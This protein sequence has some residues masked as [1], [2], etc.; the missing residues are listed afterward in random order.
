M[1][2]S[3]YLR[4]AEKHLKSC[5]AFLS[6]YQPNKNNDFE[7]FMELF[8]ITGYVLEG[9]TVYS[10]YKIYG[11]PSNVAI[12]DL[13]YYDPR[14]IRRTNLDFFHYRTIVNSDGSRSN[15]IHRG[16]KVRS[17]GFQQ[18]TMQLL[19]NQGPFVNDNLT[20][21]YG[22]GP[23]DSNVRLLINLWSPEVR[24]Y[25]RSHIGVSVLPT[26]NKEL[27]TKLIDTCSL[28]FSQTISRVGI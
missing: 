9:L 24:Y 3:E 5:K 13:N 16:L 20:P 10:A 22:N 8:Y 17:H 15:R 2:Y 28:I 23:L 11:W 27:I 26:L 14:F 4:C 7:V 6:S 12:D 21:Y 25:H 19:A 1:L 18:I